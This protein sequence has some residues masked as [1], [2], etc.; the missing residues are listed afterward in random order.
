MQQWWYGLSGPWYDLLLRWCMLPLGGERV[1]RRELVRWCEINPGQAVLSLCCGNGATERLMLEEV[2]GAQITAVDLGR[3]QIAR[4]RRLDRHNEIEYRLGDARRTG[5]PAASFDRVLIIAALH[6]MPFPQRREVLREALRLCRPEGHVVAIEH[7][8]PRGRLSRL[9]RHLWWFYWVPGN[10]EYRTTID[11]QR[12]GLATELVE[13]G[14]EVLRC[15]R[16]RPDWLEGVV[17][18]PSPG[19]RRW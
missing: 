5:L 11:L 4:A 19:P 1:C 3:G 14:L 13:A 8:R 18:R 9:L 17:A 7:A 16:T 2:P 10:P 12:R 15:H 6:E